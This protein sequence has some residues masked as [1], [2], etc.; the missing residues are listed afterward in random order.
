MLPL[1][2]RPRQ[3]DHDA[4]DQGDCCSLQLPESEGGLDASRNQTSRV[5]RN[6]YHH[7]LI[8]QSYLVRSPYPLSRRPSASFSRFSS[9]STSHSMRRTVG[10]LRTPPEQH[11][12]LRPNI[13]IR[14]RCF[15][16]EQETHSVVRTPPGRPRRQRTGIRAPFPRSKTEQ[17]TV[18]FSWTLHGRPSLRRASVSIGSPVLRRAGD[19]RLRFDACIR[20][21]CRWIVIPLLSEPSSTTFSQAINRREI[22]VGRPHP[23]QRTCR[24][25]ILRRNP[26]SP[27]HPLRLERERMAKGGLL[28]PTCMLHLG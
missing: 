24:S 27:V 14:G 2:I 21:S 23:R 19:R 1:S 5:R 18:D 10:F 6:G 9:S 3:R 20:M 4:H 22:F 16:I 28:W 26:S 12:L 13:S 15:R 17:E 7:P 11:C 25:Q 8:G